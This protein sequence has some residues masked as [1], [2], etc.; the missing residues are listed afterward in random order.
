MNN[1]LQTAIDAMRAIMDTEDMHVLASEYNRHVNFLRKSKGRSVV[2]GDTIV[3]RYG[4][5]EKTGKVVKVNR[6]SV[7]VVNTGATP[8]GATRTRVD[9]SLITGKVAA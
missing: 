9:K 2:L 8:F 6:V 4:G 1:T 3:W 7:E 5:L